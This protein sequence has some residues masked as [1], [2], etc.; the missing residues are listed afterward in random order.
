MLDLLLATE[1]GVMLHTS[2]SALNMSSYASLQ[3]ER[4]HG[5]RL[6]ST[7]PLLFVLCLVNNKAQYMQ[8]SIQRLHGV[9]VTEIRTPPSYRT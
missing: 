9:P 1:C 7:E 3:S 4:L 5:I 6:A 2:A 8:P